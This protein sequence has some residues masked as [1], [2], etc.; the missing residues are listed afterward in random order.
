MESF[1]HKFKHKS[2]LKKQQQT[3]RS[4]KDIF[5][6]KSYEEEKDYIIEKITLD[7][8]IIEQLNH[9]HK[10]VDSL[11]SVRWMNTIA[12]KGLEDEIQVI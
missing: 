1:L 10:L 5:G 6:I 4:L 12:K 7:S 2:I 8:S 9:V 11:G 3:H